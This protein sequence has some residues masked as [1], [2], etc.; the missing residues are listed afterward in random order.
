MESISVG[1]HPVTFDDNI[2]YHKYIVYEN[3]AGTQVQI[4]GGGNPGYV[5][6]PIDELAGAAIGNQTFGKLKVTIIVKPANPND[7]NEVILTGSNLYR[8]FIELTKN[9]YLLDRLDTPYDPYTHNSNTLIDQ[10]LAMTGLQLPKLDERY[11]SPG[12]LDSAGNLGIF[13]NPL[14]FPATTPIQTSLTATTPISAIRIGDTVLAFDPYTDHGRG[15]LMARRVTKLFHNTTTEWLKLAWRDEQGETQ[16]LVCTP[17][18]HFLDEHGNFPAIADMVRDGKARIVLASGAVAEVAV[19]RIAYSQATADLFE[20]AEVQAMVMGSAAL[21]P[22]ALEAWTTYNFEVEDLHTY[23]AAGVRVHNDSLYS[24]MTD[25]GNLADQISGQIS[26]HI[27]GANI[28][29]A[30][31]A[32]SAL[33]AVTSPL[34]DTYQGQAAFNAAHLSGRFAANDNDAMARAAA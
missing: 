4:H 11:W 12:S 34:A 8:Q 15:A 9:A 10:V 1:Y 29:G 33:S 13:A 26:N 5:G 7:P 3:S 28:F 19:S 17:G 32:G 2:L 25:L 16:E 31:F 24:P 30:V 18:H 14:C 22:Q 27:W 6:S 20:Q 21:A 23:V